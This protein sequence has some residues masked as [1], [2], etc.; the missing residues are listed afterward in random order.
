M[1]R[2]LRA[3]LFDLDDTL[4]SLDQFVLSGVRRVGSADHLQRTK[5]LDA[6]RVGAVLRAAWMSPQRG[7]ELQA[8]IEH[9]GL[10]Q[11][12]VAE[13]LEVMRGHRPSRSPLLRIK[14][15]SHEAA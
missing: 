10:D 8:C 13:L 3:V 12:M 4:Y 7:R 1:S 2:E 14:T 5:A 6:R 15:G 9:F 11:P